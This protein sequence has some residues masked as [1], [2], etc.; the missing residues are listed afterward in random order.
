MF[1]LMFTAEKDWNN[2]GRLSQY[3][4]IVGANVEIRLV[5]CSSD[6]A[7]ALGHFVEL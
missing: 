2:I 6:D 3:D 1:C 5:V 7:K 4:P